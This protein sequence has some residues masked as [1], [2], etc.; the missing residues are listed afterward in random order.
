MIHRSALARAAAVIGLFA[1]LSASPAW[2]AVITFAY[3]GTVDSTSG[4]AAFDAFLGQTIR[5]EYTFDS[6][7]ADIFPADPNAGRYPAVLSMTATAGPYSATA[8]D[9][10]ITVWDNVFG[11]DRYRVD[12]LSLSGAPIGGLPLDQIFIDLQDNTGLAFTDD[13]L[14][15]VQPDPG[16]F[17]GATILSLEFDDGSNNGRIATA[18]SA[19]ISPVAD[20]PIPEPGTLALL[21]LGLAGLGYVRRRRTDRKASE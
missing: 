20:T 15:L 2:A 7:T 19:I 12:G 17:P 1:G 10:R 4:G 13:F 9:G 8:A 6:T 14:P 11:M 16:D 21:G 18:Q 5:I 3:E